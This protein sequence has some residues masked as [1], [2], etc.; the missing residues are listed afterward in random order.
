MITIRS[1]SECTW[2]QTLQ[3]WNESFSDYF[4]NMNFTFDQLLYKMA[5]EKISPAHSLVAWANDQPVG[6]VLTAIGDV[7]GKKVAWN[8]GTAIL[9]GWRRR[10]IGSR[11]MAAL[12]EFYQKEH[13]RQA[14][15]EAF[16]QN[17]SAIQLYQQHGYEI[18]GYLLIYQT[19][20]IKRIPKEVPGFKIRSDHPAS[21]A[22]FSF[23][24]QIAPWQ[25]HWFL[26]DEAFI[27]FDSAGKETGYALVKRNTDKQGQVQ[28]LSLL[29]LE[30]DPAHPDADGMT[31][32]LLQY[33]ITSFPEAS[34]YRFLYCPPQKKA[35]TNWLEKAGFQ[36]FANNVHMVKKI[37]AD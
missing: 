30:V 35:V 18:A 26:G 21:V 16:A 27:I 14:T 10:G 15:L 25:T 7:N 22:S 32:Q 6:F 33:V 2:E 34:R 3:L 19:D 8:G 28:A 36:I 23:Y 37:T 24:P 4:V 13:V 29:Q 9:P 31:H 20:K 17:K 12:I 11:L 1:F 5:T